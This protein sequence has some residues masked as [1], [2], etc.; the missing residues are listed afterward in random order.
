MT[1]A[2][3]STS[4]EQ[5]VRREQQPRVACLRLSWSIASNALGRSGQTPLTLELELCE[6]EPPRATLDGQAFQ[7][8]SR[9]ASAWDG[10]L[11]RCRVGTGP[12]K[13][14]LIVEAAPIVVAV[15]GNDLRPLHVAC[16]LPMALGLG[17]GR[18]ELVA[19][20]LTH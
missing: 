6:G 2:P 10:T 9:W 5:S 17:G 15:L 1:T 11:S 18:Y 7:S 19:G 12:G 16:D 4:F 8:A 14:L 13:G 3:P 20:G